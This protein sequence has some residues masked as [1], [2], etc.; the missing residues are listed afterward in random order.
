MCSSKRRPEDVIRGSNWE[1]S[2]GASRSMRANASRALSAS[3]SL[4]QAANS[5]N[6]QLPSMRYSEYTCT[7]HRRFTGYIT[8]RSLKAERLSACLK[9]E[10]PEQDGAPGTWGLSRDAH[11]IVGA[12][13]WL[14][15]SPPHGVETCPGLLPAA[16]RHS[17]VVSHLHA[18]S[19]SALFT[20][21]ALSSCVL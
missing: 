11:G 8:R 15:P 4:S 18:C 7:W 19:T 1:M 6:Q 16:A 9:A 21:T 10:G 2:P 3:L 20:D 12:S 14:H 13:V 5:C 17:L